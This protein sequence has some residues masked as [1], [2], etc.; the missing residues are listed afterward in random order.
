MVN[1]TFLSLSFLSVLILLSFFPFVY[2]K[3]IVQ[4]QVQVFPAEPD[5]REVTLKLAGSSCD[6]NSA[7]SAVLHLKGVVAV[8][9]EYKKDHLLVGYDPDKVTPQQM[10]DAIGKKRGCNAIVVGVG[11]Q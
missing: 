4:A 8:D 6:M 7:E 3:P 11:R 5:I 2:E 9:V 10:V 1:R